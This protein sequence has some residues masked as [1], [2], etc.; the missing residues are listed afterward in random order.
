MKRLFVSFLVVCSACACFAATPPKGLL[1]APLMAVADVHT[2]NLKL[3]TAEDGTRY[4]AIRLRLDGASGVRVYISGMQ[5][6]AGQKLLVSNLTGTQVYGP[7]ETAGP[8]QS[9][10]FWSEA[11]E[12]SDVIV[13]LQTGPDGV[14]DLPFKI[15][16]IEAAKISDIQV[17]TVK[18]QR[19]TV[20][21]LY[22]GVPVTH[23]VVDGMAVY[24]GDILLGPA[25]E[26]PRAQPGTKAR[27]RSSVGI[28]GSK[29][30]W[31]GATMP[32]VIAPD[33]PT[34]SRVTG[35]IDHW[36]AVM[37]GTVR[38]VPRTNETAYVSF[39]RAASAGTCSSY[40]GKV[41]SGAQP[42][43]IG[44]SC[45]KGNVIHEIGHAW[46]LW[47]EHTR[48]DRNRYVTVNVENIQA[49]ES[50]NFNQNISTGD[51]IGGYDYGSIMHYNTASFSANG[52]PTIV[53]VPAGIPI[54]QRSALSTGDIAGVKALYPLSAVSVP[55]ATVATTITANP[56]GS[57]VSVDGLVYTTPASF[58][59]PIGSAHTIAAVNVTDSSVRKAFV[60]WSDNGAQSH[61]IVA[62]TAATLQVDYAVAY[63]VKATGGPYGTAAISPVSA[64]TFYPTG[65]TVT[66]M[67]TPLSGYCFTGW[68][69][70]IAGTPNRTTVLA[71]R[72]YDIQANFQ[73]GATSFTPAV[74][75]APVEGGA[76]TASVTSNAGCLWS[77]VATNWLTFTQVSAMSGSGTIAFT[78]SPN[79]TGVA[80]MGYITIGG[81]LLTVKQ[82]GI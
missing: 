6:T 9:G 15:E 61:T 48:E 2:T 74:I 68:G 71:T 77:P 49:G 76:F 5:L 78:V 29:Y 79:T 32:Y 30:R 63:S 73:T 28:T 55:L 80:R 82:A 36:N 57:A 41:F 1:T 18:Q 40:I 75:A 19:E 59:W 66:L 58:N 52:L 8:T 24:E 47:H 65:R 31:P 4:I 10:E 33:I 12:G 7:Y 81:K 53:T 67:A 50:H 23:N 14:G 70:L 35:A 69:G 27:V 11:I 44:N 25:S 22:N 46:G 62:S 39:V 64:D 21:S 13:E 3:E 20:E 16:A 45:S 42:I 34:P 51:D 72:G 56:V 26:L 37:L 38:M 54:G 60:K 17:P 43:Q